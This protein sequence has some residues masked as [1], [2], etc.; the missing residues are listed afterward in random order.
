M[1][2]GGACGL[3][4]LPWWLSGKESACNAGDVSLIPGSGRSP[5]EGNGNPLQ[6]SCLGNPVDRGAWQAIVHGAAK[7]VRHSW[8]TKQQKISFHWETG[9]KVIFIT[10]IFFQFILLSSV[11][12]TKRKLK[13]MS[14]I[15]EQRTNAS[16]WKERFWSH[17]PSCFYSLASK[18]HKNASKQN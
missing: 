1:K 2:L 7:R 11:K 18:V 12:N 4:G 6:Y 5:G 9:Y 14:N 17:K 10:Y 3:G 8:A 13:P 16:P 15:P